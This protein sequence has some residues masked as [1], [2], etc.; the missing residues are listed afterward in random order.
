MLAW[1]TPQHLRAHELNITC[2]CAGMQLPCDRHP[3][4]AAHLAEDACTMLLR[5][6]VVML[7]IA[8]TSKL[9]RSDMTA[10]LC[11]MR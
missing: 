4:S 9:L 10:A 6:G 2:A 1:A 8:S 7:P 3:L 11:S 5:Q